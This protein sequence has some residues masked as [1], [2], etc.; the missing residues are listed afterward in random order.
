MFRTVAKRLGRDGVSRVSRIRVGSSRLPGALAP[1]WCL[2]CKKWILGPSG[3]GEFIQKL[4]ARIILNHR[5]ALGQLESVCDFPAA[6]LAGRKLG[7]YGYE[8]PGLASSPLHATTSASTCVC[9]YKVTTSAAPHSNDMSHPRYAGRAVK[10][11][12]ELW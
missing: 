10:R 12:D 2:L 9:V 3:G 6:G 5:Q 7:T 4:P 8:C 11:T 1:G